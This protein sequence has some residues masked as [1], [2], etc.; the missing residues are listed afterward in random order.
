MAI[1]DIWLAASHQKNALAEIGRDRGGSGGEE[2]L[3]GSKAKWSLQLKT[4]N[5]VCELD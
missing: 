3:E 1:P 5:V 4:E 2:C